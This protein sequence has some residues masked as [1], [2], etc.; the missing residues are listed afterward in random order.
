M[1]RAFSV[2]PVDVERSALALGWVPQLTGLRVLGL[3]GEDIPSG[4]VGRHDEPGRI[5]DIQAALRHRQCGER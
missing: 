1:E 3:H 4:L 5:A 2:S